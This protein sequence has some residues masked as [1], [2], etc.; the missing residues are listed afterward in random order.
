MYRHDIADRLRQVLT[1]L[2]V[3]G[4]AA[5]LSKRECRVLAEVGDVKCASLSAS[6]RWPLEGDDAVMLLARPDRLRRARDLILRFG[7]HN[8]GA[9]PPRGAPPQSAAARTFTFGPSRAR[10]RLPH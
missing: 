5:L 4:G 6:L 9:L 2:A 7:L 1:F 8:V 10:Q 3:S